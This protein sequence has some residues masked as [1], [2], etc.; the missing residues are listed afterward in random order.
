M[1][2]DDEATFKRSKKTSKHECTVVLLD[3]GSNMA[4][5]EAGSERC[6]MDL[7]KEVLDWILTRKI[8]SKSPDEFTLILF[9]S[10]ETRNSFASGTENIYFCE[11][12]M[13]TAKIDWLK[14]IDKEVKPSKHVQGD[15][16]A[17]LIVAVD[18]MRS[19]LEGAQENEITGRNILLLT[20]LAGYVEDDLASDSSDAI[21]IANGMKALDVNFSVIGPSVRSWGDGGDERIRTSGDISPTKDD[22]KMEIGERI[23]SDIAKRVDGVIYTFKGPSVRSWGDGG[24][25]R[26][27]TSG[28]ISPTK[29]DVKMEIGERIL[30][31]IAKRV[32][33]V[34]YT[35][36]EAL[37]MLQHF[38]PRKVNIRGQRFFLELGEDLK[39]PLVLFKKNQEPD[40]KMNFAK[41]D[42][43]S[44]AESLF[45]EENNACAYHLR[46]I[47]NRNLH[48]NI[49]YIRQSYQH[50]Y[51]SVSTININ[52]HINIYI[53]EALPMLQ[54]F[55]PRK[56]N[57][58]GQRFFL[59]L[60]EDLK[61]PLVLFK[62]NQ[63]PDMK[64]NFA[65]VDQT[66]G[67]E[68]KRQTIYERPVGDDSTQNAAL[69]ASNSG[70]QVLRKEDVIKGYTFGSTVVPFNDEDE[71]EY[72]WKRESRCMKLLQFSKRSDILEHYLMDG[73]VYYCIPP[74]NDQ[75]GATAVSALVRAMLEEDSVALVRYVYNAASSPRIMALF[76]RTSSK[77]VDMLMGI[78]LPF[79]EDFR[80]LEFPPIDDDL[81][82]PKAE[83]MRAVEALVDAMDL[84]KSYLD[85]ETGE[86]GEDLRPR[87]VPNPKLQRVC[88]AMKHRALH[89]GEEL[90]EFKSH[91]LNQLFEPRP[92]LLK[93]ASEPLAWIKKSFVLQEVPSRKRKGNF[94]EDPLSI[95]AFPSFGEDGSSLPADGRF[96]GVDEVKVE[97]DTKTE[98]IVKTEE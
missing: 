94:N 22:V 86:C 89:P 57:I 30:S 6:A 85:P 26:I 97:G 23:L 39:L 27:R 51:I 95:D 40:M 84:S 17:A 67:A 14:L 31:D 33:G 90:A 46:K 69:P 2:D 77:G 43:T 28:D 44:G 68:V 36:K 3:V 56:V 42:Q 15:F 24:D 64:M 55:V 35:F 1:S 12:E 81:Y 70:P 4:A 63:E 8:F 74:A 72:G 79:Y 18:Y 59:E 16:I 98:D 52:N 80:G 41:V 75:E 61:L 29:D 11:E 92:S 5:P 62:K 7:A 38:V 73:G 20:N 65:K 83:Q 96:I 13:Q 54:H 71:K 45:R 19:C 9:G 88:E 34:I 78:L 76:P 50:I 53:R 58:R 48:T 21:A 87:N 60:G 32:D 82:K 91:I 66:S 93:L 49:I 37:P 47:I 10:D 25:E